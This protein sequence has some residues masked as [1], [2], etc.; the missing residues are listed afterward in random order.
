LAL[1]KIHR[2]LNIMVAVQ[3]NSPWGA[4]VSGPGGERSDLAWG[5]YT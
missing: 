2:T 3:P 1:Q 5:E 4:R